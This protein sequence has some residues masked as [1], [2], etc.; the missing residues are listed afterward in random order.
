MYHVESLRNE[1]CDARLNFNG[2]V[3]SFQAKIIN[4]AL[5]G[6]NSIDILSSVSRSRLGRFTHIG[7]FSYIQRSVV[8]RYTSIGSRC[9]IGGMN[10]PM[11]WLS[12]NEFQYR[13]MSSINGSR[14]QNRYDHQWPETD[15]ETRIGNDVWIGDNV[16][17]LP[18]RSIGSGAVVGAGSVVTKDIPDY[19]VCAGN[20]AKLIRLRFNSL[21][22][23][24]LLRLKWWDRD[25]ETI[26]HL[27]FSDINL[28][29]SALNE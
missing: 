29:I 7:C 14:M 16:V 21:Q 22:I 2:V 27:P 18:G 3:L 11:T 19:S 12:T 1:S 10:H 5:E 20:P 4:S 6:Y 15:N 8:G 25:H 28:C 23:E 26:S 9:S 17:V 24:Q 13:N